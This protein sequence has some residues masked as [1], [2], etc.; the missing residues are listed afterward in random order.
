MRPLPET[1]KV[2]EAEGAVLG[3][4]ESAL[5]L[6]G[7]TYMTPVDTI[8]IPVAR[9]DPDFFVL[10]TGVAGEFVQKMVN[11][12]K[13]LVI[14]GDITEQAAASEPLRDWIRESNRRDDLWFVADL[15]E[16]AGRL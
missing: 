10:R 3:S 4:S 5:D 6:I 1:V 9:L 7:D 15:E 13:R 8:A 2:L 14:V 11:Y 12:R 16:L